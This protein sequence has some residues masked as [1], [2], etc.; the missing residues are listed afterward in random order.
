MLLMDS[1]NIVALTET[2]LDDAFSDREL[3]LEGYSTFRRD[4]CVRRG[5][6]VLL[7][8][9]SHIPCVR[10]CD[11]EVDAE[12]L[13]CELRTSNTRCLLFV[14]F[15]RPPDVGEGFLDEFKKFLQ[16]S[17][18]TGIADLVITGNFNF[19]HVDWSTGSPST[20]DSLTETFCEILDDYFLTQTN[21]QITRSSQC[22]EDFVIW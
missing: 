3:H 17:A 16:Y 2:W 12:M 14:V 4:R 22:H 20:V 21:F 18:G 7:A 6:G 13:V 1:F 9:K 15:Y 8:I 19:P 11:L 5:G 10:R